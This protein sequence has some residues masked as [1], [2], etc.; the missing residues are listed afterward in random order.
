MIG[1]I[2][3][4]QR[5]SARVAGAVYLVSFATVVVVNFGVLGPL[6]DGDPAHIARSV[7]E[8]ETRFR[9]GLVGQLLYCIGVLVVTGALYIVL[10][11]VDGFL[12]VLAAVGRLVHGLSWLLVS[13][14]LLT[15][16]RLL[17]QPVYA[18]ALPPDQLPVLARLYLSGFDQ[19]YVGLLFWSL[20]S[21]VTAYLWFKAGYVPRPL[22]LVGIPASAWGAACCIALFVFPEFPK[23]VNLWWFDMPMVL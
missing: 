22:A 20:G 7:L 14:N 1:S 8:H 21:T 4:L 15:A 6:L 9:V 17:T 11:P 3:G 2:D 12:A 16:L 13:L 19:Y 10:R 18:H 23:L 5:R